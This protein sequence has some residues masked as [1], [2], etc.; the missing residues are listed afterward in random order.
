[1]VSPCDVLRAGVCRLAEF[2][3]DFK[4]TEATPKSL[5]KSLAGKVT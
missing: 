3:Q 5:L 4:R 2:K 1:M